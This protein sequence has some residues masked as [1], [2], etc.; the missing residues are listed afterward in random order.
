[1]SLRNLLRI[2]AVEQDDTVA[3]RDG[4]HLS[5]VENDCLAD[6]RQPARLQRTFGAGH[7]NGVERA[8][9]HTSGAAHARRGLSFLD[10]RAR[11]RS[12]T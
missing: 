6:Q 8:A 7:R 3:E 5:H 10:L 12:R 2:G 1:M 4:G 11:P 9:A